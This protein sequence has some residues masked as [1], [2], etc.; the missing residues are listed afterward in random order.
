D[1]SSGLAALHA[2]GFS[3]VGTVHDGP[4]YVCRISGLPGPDREACI[5]TPP[6]SAY[7]A[8]WHA[9]RGGA[10]AYS[11]TGAASYDPAPGSVEGWAF[12]AGAQPGVAPP[13]PPAPPPAPPR[14]TARPTT[15]PPA[16]PPAPAPV[17]ATRSSAPGAPPPASAGPAGPPGSAG[18]HGA[19]GP[20]GGAASTYGRPSATTAAPG[21]TTSPAAPGTAVTSEPTVTSEPGQPLTEPAASSGGLT[22]SLIGLA[23]VL[24][25][26]AAAF[27]VIRRRA[28]GTPS[29]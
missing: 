28:R 1:P 16:P 15:P 10:W 18:S 22:G 26:A 29:V 27:F 9:R 24:A 21:V 8:Y 5:R 12:G 14:P 20:S 2:A 17:P 19:G 23:V 4:G 3:T 6:S 25:L 11:S 7:W 13:A